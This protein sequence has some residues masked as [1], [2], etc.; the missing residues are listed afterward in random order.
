MEHR[1]LRDVLYE[2]HT[3]P[4]LHQLGRLALPD[5]RVHG[6]GPYP[7]VLV[8]HAWKGQSAF[9]QDKARALAE[10]GYVAM[11]GDVYGDAVWEAEAGG[12]AARMRP[13]VADRSV[14]RGR[15]LAGIA[16]LRSQ[17]EVDARRVAVIGFCFGGLCALE[18]ARSG[19]DVRAAVAFHGLLHRGDAPTARPMPARVLVEHGWD[20]PMAPPG[21]VVALAAELTEADAHW[22]LH[23]HGGVVHAF[24]NPAAADRAGGLHY[25]ADADRRSWAS[26]R[27]WL[28]DSFA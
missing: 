7:A 2:P 12:A 1:P 17:P 14:L 18:V 8:C 9:E 25:D 23:A 13:L 15:L 5:A 6:P 22:A 27:A 20:D 16:A 24:T 19:A 3:E 26:M 10:L 28:Q 11:A 4:A 21:H